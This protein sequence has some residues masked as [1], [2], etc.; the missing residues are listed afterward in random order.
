MPF[1]L[2]NA[3]AIFQFMMNNIFWPYLD[4]FAMVYLNDIV[5]YFKTKEEYLKHFEKVLKVLANH[6]IYAKP[7]ECIIVIKSLEFYGP[8]MENNIMKPVASKIKIINKWPIAKTIHEIWQFLGLA[9][10]Y[11]QIVKEFAQMVGPLFDILKVG[12][13]EIWK[14][15]HWPIR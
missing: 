13:V 9:L 10:Y 3:L 6:W 8:I 15:K 2:K 7:S 11:S 12:N 4:K 14:K 5:I 1:E